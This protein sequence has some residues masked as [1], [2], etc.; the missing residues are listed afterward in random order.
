MKGKASVIIFRKKTGGLFL[1][2]EG[3]ITRKLWSLAMGLILMIS[4]TI[5]CNADQKAKW[6][7]EENAL[8]VRN[9]KGEYIG[10]A[11]HVLVDPSTGNV[12]FIIL[13]L[14][15]EKKE[16]VI[17]LRSFSSFDHEKVALVLGISKD[18]L[19]AAPD[20]RLSDLEDPA[21]ID[22]VYRFFG[23]APSWTDGA[24]EGERRM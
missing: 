15:K 21:F 2:G 9:W 3:G 5:G 23:Q 17:P 18:I 13:L 22:K 7:N 12:A 1:T 16:I 6:V 19:V 14:D 11:R 24:I 10:S 4:G 8:V 20:F